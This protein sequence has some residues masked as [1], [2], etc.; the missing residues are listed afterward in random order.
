DGSRPARRFTAGPA[1]TTP[2]WSPD[3]AALAFVADRG[4]GA[5][6]HVAS[7]EGGDPRC[8]TSAPHGLAQPAWSP[9]G[10]RLAYVARTGEWTEPSERSAV[11]RSAPRVVRG[12]RYR[13]D[14]IGW[15][16]ERRSHLFV[17]DAERDGAEPEQVTD[18][19]WDDVDPAWSP[20]GRSL[21]FASDRSARRADEEH[22]DVWVVAARGAP[23][24]PRPRRLT[25]G[26]GT[27]GAPRWSPDG[28]RIA[29]IGHEHDD[30]D[31]AANTH[32]LV[33][34]A[35]GKEPPRSLSAALD[36]TVWGLVRAPGATQVWEDGGE[37]LLFLAADGGTLA[38][39][40]TRVDDPKPEPVVT[41]DRQVTAL[42]AAAGTVAFTSQ[43][44]SELPEVH[45][46]DGDG[47]RRISDVNADLR[48][49]VRLAPTRRQTHRAEDGTL[50]ESFVVS[51]DAR[52]QGA[53]CL[54]EIHGG[55]HGWHPQVTMLGLY[56]SLASEGYIIVLPNPRGSHGYGEEFA[57]ACVG[58]WGG[59]DFADLM[60]A[61]DHLVERGIA[62]PERLYVAGYSYGGF[63]TSW[64]VGHTD[65]FAAAC[66]SAPVTDVL[67]MWGTTDIPNFNTYE[68]GGLPWER[69]EAYAERSPITY[70]RD[71]T[72]PVAIF[73][74][75]GDLR[76]PMGQSE[77]LFQAL[78]KLGR[79]VVFVRY[80]DGFHILRSP[81]Q[82][83][84]YVNRHL[85][86]F[87]A[88]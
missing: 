51:A 64:V 66:I 83:L 72:T 38:L 27:A 15:F 70:V 25:R 49:E 76:T 28:T 31:S 23:A 61:V 62:D 78:R 41:G 12:L 1:D 77:E 4:E 7:L 68:L 16:D 60:G 80:P 48:R 87:A 33:V 30:G 69:P 56:Q 20:D 8:L 53:P 88:H 85:E 73:H 17:V 79:E 47:T 75:E 46:V 55:P 13:F 74:W 57:S 71:V 65:R 42:H 11:E 14:G 82:M 52:P 22:R 9:D 67:S 39:Y 19:D 84:D 54:L 40:R 2:R 24:V 43:W 45:V 36:R 44:S 37:S 59:A 10:R 6:L 50:I 86:W 34:P 5:Q 21:A 63:M 32:V 58:D 18:G 3:G 26:R 29:Y 35:A 81:S